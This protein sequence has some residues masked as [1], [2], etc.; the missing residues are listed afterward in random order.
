MG[1]EATEL[2]MTKVLK[3]GIPLVQWL[4]DNVSRADDDAVVEKLKVLIEEEDEVRDVCE[5]RWIA[6]ERAWRWKLYAQLYDV[7]K[8]ALPPARPSFKEAAPDEGSDGAEDAWG[9]LD[10][11]GCSEPSFSAQENP[12]YPPFST[13][14]RQNLRHLALNFASEL[15]LRQARILAEECSLDSMILCDQIPLHAQPSDPD[16]GC[17]LISLLPRPQPRRSSPRNPDSVIRIVFRGGHQEPELYS[18]NQLTEWYLRRV[19]AID[20]NTGHIDTAIE[21]VQHGASFGIHGLELIAEDLNLLS[22]LLYEAPDQSKCQWTL[23]DWRSKSSDEVVDAYLRGSTPQTLTRNINRL[24]L[25]YLGVMES[26]RAR[27]SAPSWETTIPDAIRFWALSQADNLPLLAAIIQASSPTLR[28]PE[29]SIK[30]NEELAR[31]AIACVYTSSRLDQWNLMNKIFECMPAFPDAEPVPKNFRASEFLRDLFNTPEV[32]NSSSDITH[33]LYQVLTKTSAG[34]LSAILDGLDDH[35]TT[36]EVLARWN[37]PV[38]LKDL[39]IKFQ[40]NRTEQEKLATKMARQEG[41]LEMESE[42]EWEALMEGMIELSCPGRVFDGLEKNHIMRL[43]FSGLLTSGKFKLA[44]ALFSS[45]CGGHPL[46][47]DVQEELVICAS[48]EYYDNAESGNQNVGEMRLAL[49]CLSAARSTPQIQNER[50]F[51]EATSRLASFK[52]C[53]QPGVLMT[54]IQIRL[55]PNKLDLIEQ[56]LS[57]NGDA[58]KH[59][60]M[61]LELVNKLGFGHDALSQIRAL[62]FIVESA[63]SAGD[64]PVANETCHRMVT[65]LGTMKKRP[66]KLEPQEKLN[67]ASEV[68]WRMCAKLGTCSDTNFPG[69]DPEKRS[70]LLG[71]AII[72][73][74]A[75]EISGLL[76]KWREIEAEELMKKCTSHDERS[77]LMSRGASNANG[78][79]SPQSNSRPNSRMSNLAN[80]ASSLTGDIAIRAA[81]KTFG[82]AAALFPFKTRNLSLSASPRISTPTTALG[83]IDTRVGSDYGSHNHS[84]SSTPSHEPTNISQPL[85]NL[86]G[87]DGFGIGADRLTT[88][89]SN[90]FTSGVGWLIGAN[91]EV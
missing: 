84:R 15:K 54:P 42:D 70:V 46:S 37:V 41:G 90:K 68:V 14:L 17:D 34:S 23:D 75:E 9:E 36:A 16:H 6:S 19:N 64:F 57:T 52:L 74:P 1:L 60:D 25:P 55:K 27:I 39:I 77:P 18:N 38:R 13:F 56:L 49:E 22:K 71:H 72:L 26:R 12:D 11:E 91:E 28:L 76:A 20:N 62:A 47:A 87:E 5:A 10:L 67:S 48:R 45:S 4:S 66:R 29:R 35:L 80:S 69:S 31:I 53:S 7:D 21:F 50:D 58:Y 65:V 40:G 85:A 63:I 8:T 33:Q 59:Q 86:V 78:N 2:W 44:K 82:K 32:L 24:V 3:D 43:F 30:N 89:L 73:C 83:Q 79:D 88:A 51:I 61:I 81:S